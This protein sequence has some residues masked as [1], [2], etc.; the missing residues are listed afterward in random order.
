MLLQVVPGNA[1]EGRHLAAIKG[2]F[3]EEELFEVGCQD[4]TEE[5]V[6]ERCD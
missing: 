1:V 6:K 5:D 3:V 2:G 4:F